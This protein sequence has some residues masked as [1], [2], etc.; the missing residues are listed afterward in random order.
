M[1]FAAWAQS[2]T[3]KELLPATYRPIQPCRYSPWPPA[4]GDQAWGRLCLLFEVSIR[5]WAQNFIVT[6][7]KLS[8]EKALLS[9]FLHL[10][11]FKARLLCYCLGS[12]LAGFS[13]LSG[14]ILVSLFECFWPVIARPVL[15]HR[16]SLSISRHL[17]YL[18]LH[19]NLCQRVCGQDFSQFRNCLIISGDRA[20]CL[21]NNWVL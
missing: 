4:A 7:Q 1:L 18:V 16:V 17:D 10:L 8:R 12:L 15:L 9:W 14:V 21:E 2:P 3:G 20:G 19:N 5:D 11:G 6:I 13:F